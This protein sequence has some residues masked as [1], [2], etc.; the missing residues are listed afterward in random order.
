MEGEEF[1][2]YRVKEHISWK[3]TAV[4]LSTHPENIYKIWTIAL[5]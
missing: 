3:R 5:G 1:G 4:N 2:K